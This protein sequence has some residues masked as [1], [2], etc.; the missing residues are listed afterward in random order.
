MFIT[1]R[2]FRFIAAMALSIAL[3]ASASGCAS[4]F[5]GGAVANDTP[6]RQLVREASDVNTICEAAYVG[7]DV[8][9]KSGK[10]KPALMLALKPYVDAIEKGRRE[11]MAQA[12]AGNV[13]SFEATRTA[14][15]ASLNQLALAQLGVPIAPTSQP[16]EIPPPPET[17]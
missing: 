16:S 17:P 15:L 6:Q 13:A 9:Y 1:M 2:H 5:G 10:V 4:L 7:L 12:T 11:L 3:L 8:A 14:I